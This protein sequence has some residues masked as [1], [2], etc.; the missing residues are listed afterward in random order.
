MVAKVCL[1]SRFILSPKSRPVLRKG[2][3]CAGNNVS[4]E[5]QKR[6][7]ENLSKP[8]LGQ[9]TSNTLTQDHPEYCG[10]Y[11]TEG[12]NAVLDSQNVGFLQ[13]NR[14]RQSRR[15]KQHSHCLDEHVPWEPDSLK[16][17]HAWHDGRARHTSQNS[18]RGSNQRTDPRL[19]TCGDCQL[20]SPQGHHRVCYEQNTKKRGKQRKVYAR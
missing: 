5:N 8:S 13:C 9:S 20:D 4:A 19:V 3:Q 11:G 10:K 2:C 12:K 18:I 14:K 17:H 16:K 6:D 7:E 1:R 15:R